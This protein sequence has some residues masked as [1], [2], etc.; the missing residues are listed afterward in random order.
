M[1]LVL[2]AVG[3]GIGSLFG[4]P[5]LGFNLG[6]TA[7]GLLFP[8]RF[9]TTRGKLDDLRITGSGYG[10]F[11]PI[12]YGNDMVGGNIIWGQD[13]VEHKHTE[14][15]GKGG[16]GSVTEYSYTVTYA[17]L[18]CE[19]EIGGIKRIWGGDV[20]LYDNGVT[21]HDVTIYLGSETQDPDPTIEAVLGVGN[22]PAFRGSAYVVFKDLDLTPWGGELPPLLFEVSNSVTTEVILNVGNEEWV[23]SGVVLPAGDGVY[24]KCNRESVIFGNNGA[25]DW[26][27]YPEGAYKTSSSP[28][29]YPETGIYDPDVVTTVAEESA[30][31]NDRFAASNLPPYLLAMAVE[32]SGTPASP[33]SDALRPNKGAF[34]SGAEVNGG[35]GGRIWFA[36]N[37]VKGAFGNN[38]R[39]WQ[40]F[41]TPESSVT[42]KS[43]LDDLAVRA[44]LSA[45][46]YDFT[47]AAS[48]FVRGAVVPDMDAGS[49]IIDPL[50]TAFAYDL[51]EVD[52]KVKVRKLGG[53]VDHT[54]TADDLG[55][56]E[57]QG[58]SPMKTIEVEHGGEF[59]LPARVDV[60]YL[61]FPEDEDDKVYEIGQQF[62]MRYTKTHLHGKD[63]VNLPI[64]FSDREAR[65]VAEMILYR[66]W[67]ERDRYSFSLLPKWTKV[68]PGD[69]MSVPV[70]GEQVRM[71]VM[72]VNCAFPGAVQIKAVRDYAEVIDWEVEGGESGNGSWNDLS[73]TSVAFFHDVMNALKD[74]HVYDSGRPGA[75]VAA[76]F[77]S[78]SGVTV[79]TSTD[80][81]NFAQAV[82]LT[83]SAKIGTTKTTLAKFPDTA[84]WDDLNTV[85]VQLPSG[86]TV[87]SKTDRQVL[88][89]ENVVL[90]GSEV[91]QFVNVTPLGSNKFRLSR[92]LR[93]QRGTV[94]SAHAIGERVV[95]L[96]TPEVKHINLQI[97]WIDS[98]IYLKAVPFG[99]ALADV[100]S[101]TQLVTT[102]KNTCYS[103]A[104]VRGS[105][106][107]SNNLT[108]TWKRRAKVEGEWADYHDVPLDENDEAYEVDILD[109]MT[110]VRTI[111]V[112]S[113]TA[114]Y[115]AANQAADGLTPGDPIE[116]HVY[117]VGEF[118][119]GYVADRTV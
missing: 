80:D 71:R 82:Q 13:R 104:A 21:D 11:I 35:N 9:R 12:I 58:R 68:A 24:V 52:G 119:R 30:D 27:A 78:A 14:S 69:V 65:H 100:A 59:D 26:F 60:T 42:L 93:G 49:S 44:G 86:M 66:K 99:K 102:A 88:D 4:N 73:D 33:V 113:P 110:V 10:Q 75:Y 74:E 17:V 89:G 87:E 95:V 34:F 56:G 19:G 47:A 39:Q 115:S 7:A 79:Y 20:L 97:P 84:R 57:W 45:S 55:A 1:T 32:T 117:Q 116:V 2:G 109:G 62:A 72:N 46:Q 63:T 37:D 67:N 18:V 29:Q 51:I 43:I 70:N 54:L 108:I 107:G 103:P 61:T 22:T 31:P 8:Q 98:T 3:A 76:W 15:V 105:R 106:D 38:S 90:I 112:T 53:A 5:L 28:V 48:E 23:D 41:V 83:T 118:G 92:L 16:G 77:P 25:D 111:S 40:I 101:E 64:V 114:S 91:I 85:D 96:E 36:F 94:L 50:L 6:V 81:V